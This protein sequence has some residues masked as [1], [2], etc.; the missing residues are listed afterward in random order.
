MGTLSG[1][2]KHL[3]T[4]SD[5]FLQIFCDKHLLSLKVKQDLAVGILL[6]S[7]IHF[8]MCW[9]CTHCWHVGCDKGITGKYRNPE[10]PRC[11]WKVLVAMHRHYWRKTNTETMHQQL[12][13]VV[14]V[15]QEC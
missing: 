3:G 10:A 6:V 5:G 4:A 14:T 1:A 13:Q 7:Y 9:A 8:F 12:L 11:T 15:I 2:Q